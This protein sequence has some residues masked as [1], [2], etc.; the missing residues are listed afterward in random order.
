MS[1][2]FQSVSSMMKRICPSRKASSTFMINVPS[3]WLM[4]VNMVKAGSGWTFSNMQLVAPGTELRTVDSIVSVVDVSD[5]PK[6][7]GGDAVSVDPE[8]GEE[9][10]RCV[11]GFKHLRLSEFMKKL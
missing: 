2:D 8:T 11:I 10:E 7:I 3:S 4:I 1:T 5:L 6:A 9:D